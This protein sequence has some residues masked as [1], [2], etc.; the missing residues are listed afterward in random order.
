[1]FVLFLPSSL[2]PSLTTM[3]NAVQ[4]LDL[5]KDAPAVEHEPTNE[6]MDLDQEKVLRLSSLFSKL[7]ITISNRYVKRDVNNVYY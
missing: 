5:D 1:M 6:N 3:S 4:V 7:L 2:L